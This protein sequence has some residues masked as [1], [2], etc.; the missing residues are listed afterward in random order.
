MTAYEMAATVDF[1]LEAKQGLLDLRSENA[2]LRL[3]H[4][5]LPRGDEA[6]GL[7]RARAGARA[8]E[9]QGALLLALASASADALCSG[10]RTAGGGD[11]P[12][13]VQ[14]RLEHCRT[15]L[16]EEGEHEWQERLRVRPCLV[17][18]ARV[19]RGDERGETLGAQVRRSGDRPARA[20]R[21]QRQEKRIVA[22]QDGE[23]GRRR[24]QQLQR[25]GVER[26]RP[27]A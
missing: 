9:R 22:A 1:G 14:H 4:A 5:A 20:H 7:H 13:L 27:P 26:R 2:R 16:G 6:P 21:E 19:R 25:V 15:G 11:P 17:E 12:G 18:A 24:G 10:I 23:A 8:L 3:R